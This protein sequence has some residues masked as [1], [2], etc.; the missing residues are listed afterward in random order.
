MSSA[1]TKLEAE[2]RYLE[3]LAADHPRF[4]GSQQRTIR[5]HTVNQP[6]EVADGLRWRRSAVDAHHVANLVTGLPARDL[7]SMLGRNCKWGTSVASVTASI[8]HKVCQFKVRL[9]LSRPLR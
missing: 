2:A 8:S 4:V 3:T 6:A 1:H 7:W 9:R 5:V